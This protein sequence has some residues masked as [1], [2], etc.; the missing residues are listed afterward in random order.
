MALIYG[1]LVRAQLQVSASDLTPT[2]TGLVYF[3]TVS[4]LPK[5]YTGSAWSTAVDTTT[6]Q[7]ITNKTINADNNT[8]ENITNASIKAA[9]AIA[10]NKLAA[11]TASRA[12]ASDASGFVTST[13]VTSTEL[14]YLSG[15]TSNIQTQLTALGFYTQVAKSADYTV[16]DNDGYRTIFMTTSTTDRT[17]TLPTVADNVNRI[18]TV[19]KVDSASGRCRVDG[20]GAEEIGAGTVFDLHLIGDYVTLQ[21]DGTRWQVIDMRETSSENAFTP[22]FAANTLGSLAASTVTWRREGKRVSVNGTVT[23]GTVGG[24]NITLD[25]PGIGSAGT[26]PTITTTHTS[27][28]Q[29]GRWVRNNP[30]ASTRKAGNIFC[31]G[32]GSNAFVYFSSDDQA[33]AVN[34]F[35]AVAASGLFGSGDVIS[36]YFSVPVTNFDHW[37]T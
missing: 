1:E 9:A 15:V 13:S 26:L 33:A 37:G 10:L 25:L 28:L 17:V 4:G 20:E 16:L 27:G 5:W 21:S 31:I 18:I 8:L 30:S 29:V 6:G 23:A 19:K 24:S 34:P 11:V 2:A 7:T 14:G 36:F 22:A 12:L 3:N 35:T 32:N